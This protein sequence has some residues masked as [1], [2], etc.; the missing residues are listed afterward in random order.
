MSVSKYTI[1][2][3]WREDLERS[4][5]L[6]ELE[7][8]AYGFVLA[9]FETWRLKRQEAPGREVARRFWKEAVISKERKDWQLDQ[10]T[11]GIRW[12][13]NWLRLCEQSGKTPQSV[14]ERMQRAVIN[15]GA[16][17]GLALRTRR[18]YASWVA[19][20]GASVKTAK[21]AKNQELARQWLTDL[22]D[23]T[24]V[25]YS[26]QKQALNALVFFFREVLG[27]EQV[28]LGVRMRKRERHIPVVLSR[29]EV[30]TLIEKIEPKYRLKAQ[31]QYG[32]GLRISELVSLRIK[33]IDLER[34]Q[35]TIR[36]GK[37][38]K[39]RVT[40]L[41]NVL[42]ASLEAQKKRCRKLFELDRAAGAPGVALPN[43]LA[44]KMPK[45]GESWQWFWL[46]PAQKESRDP[47]SGMIRRHHIHASV[48][49][50]AIKRAVDVAG[51]EKR[52]TS[53]VLRHSFATHL[54]ESGKD[55]RT[56]QSLLGHA[57]VKTTEIY[58]HVAEGSNA[59]GVKSPLD[60]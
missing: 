18:T 58:T 43:A 60:D 35:L 25:S 31:L 40:I 17:R 12:F 20:F 8:S 2:A 47:E 1:S 56:I 14:P 10:W 7:K 50:N 52:V 5:D 59:T 30:F 32:A 53:H 11:A 9:W 49:G 54:M 57:D 38:G 19:R 27:C 55:I 48:Y 3:D 36:A 34:R 45:A 33:D 15:V 13:L 42:V 28:E 22:V 39:D 23:K 51:L 24:N 41:P 46:F 26:T 21:Q 37:G 6:S 16:R 44:R 29:K 4:R